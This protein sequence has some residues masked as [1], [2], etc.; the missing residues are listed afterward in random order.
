MK[1][2]ARQSRRLCWARGN[3]STWEQPFWQPAR[4]KGAILFYVVLIHLLAIVGV[5][6]FPLS[7][8]RVLGVALLLAAFGGMGI[9]VRSHR[10]LAHRTLRFNKFVEL[11]SH[12]YARRHLQPKARWLLVASTWRWLCQS[13]PADEQKWC[14]E[15]SRG[16]YKLWTYAQ[17]VRPR[18]PNRKFRLICDMLCR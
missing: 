8:P 1:D 16:L 3:W 14:P 6:L 7:S 17:D 2:C 5:I 15:L 11:L 9:T 13:A 10:L 12:G 18:A 4:C